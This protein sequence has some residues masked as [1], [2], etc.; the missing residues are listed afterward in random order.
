MPS[1]LLTDYRLALEWMTENGRI[2]LR[3]DFDAPGGLCFWQLDPIWLDYTE[4]PHCSVLRIRAVCPSL[5]VY[6]L[7]LHF[8]RLAPAKIPKHKYWIS[9]LFSSLAAKLFL[10]SSS[11]LLIPWLAS[12]SLQY[13]NSDLISTSARSIHLCDNPSLG[14]AFVNLQ[15][16][17]LFGH[18]VYG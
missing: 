14:L 2:S 10:S 9:P 8:W 13:G 7:Y 12:R 3:Y 4:Y 16:S 11:L 5:F 17:R 6:V 15:Y 18:R 1:A